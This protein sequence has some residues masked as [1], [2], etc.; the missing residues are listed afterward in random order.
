MLR[1]LQWLIF[2]HAHHWETLDFGTVHSRKDALSCG[3][4]FHERCTKCGVNRYRQ[5]V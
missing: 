2:G 1:L 5:D 3:R 4:W